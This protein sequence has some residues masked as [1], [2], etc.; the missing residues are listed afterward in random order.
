MN[1]LFAASESQP[2]FK[3]GGLADVVGALPHALKETSDDHIQVILPYYNQFMKDHF[4]DRLE[5]VKTDITIHLGWRRQRADLLKL[6]E[7]GITYYFIKNN[8]YFDRANIY[9]YYDDG[10]RFVFFSK[11]VIASLPHMEEEPD[12]IHCHDWQTGLVPAFLKAYGLHYKTVF[13]IHNLQYQG[14]LQNSAFDDLIN[15]SGE[16]YFG[17]EWNGL[18]NCLKAAVHHSDLIT[19]V[20]PTYAEEIKSPFF[21]EGMH[22]LLTDKS[23]IL[24]GVLNGID[25]ASYDPAND[26]YIPHPYQ[27]SPEGKRKNKESLQAELGLPVNGDIP[28]IAM[29]TRLADQKGLPLVA[30]IFPELME[31]NIQ[32]VLLGTGDPGLEQYFRDISTHYPEQASIRTYF[33]EGLA[34]RMYAGADFLLIPSRFE[35]CGLS[36]LIA[37]R[38][39]TVS[40][41]RETG[42]LKDTIHPFNPENGTGNGFTFHQSD[43]YE[44]LGCI[45]HALSVYADGSQWSSLLDNIYKAEVDWK[46]SARVYQ[47]LYQQLS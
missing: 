1:L 3:T 19:T 36:Q 13:T 23:D 28:L 43:A 10:E 4:A 44:M 34:R 21:G 16:H 5:L 32:F 12:I 7:K 20:S 14:I 26:S 25:T 22:S 27:H 33:D 31:R 42:G 37:L 47:D 9:S 8:Y 35:P 24:H 40:I 29:V 2:F 6:N 41:V 17:M 46:T 30:D 38:Y 15:L 11:A 45:D 39:E 18:I